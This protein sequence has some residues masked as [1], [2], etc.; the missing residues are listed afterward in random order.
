M[1]RPPRFQLEDVE[2]RGR[3]VA[4]ILDRKANRT[5]KVIHHLGRY[6]HFA[7]DEPVAVKGLRDCAKEALA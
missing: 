4:V 1:S 7:N 2:D 3:R 6:R 5:F